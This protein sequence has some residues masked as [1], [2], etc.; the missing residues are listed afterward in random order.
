[1]QF[2]ANIL[3]AKYVQLKCNYKWINKF[4]CLTNIIQINFNFDSNIFIKIVFTNNV[5][6]VNANLVKNVYDVISKNV[7]TL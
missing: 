4:K 6:V 5:S 1:M 2:I 7:N 3:L